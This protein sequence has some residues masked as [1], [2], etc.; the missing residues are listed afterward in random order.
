LEVERAAKLEPMYLALT[1]A[2]PDSDDQ[3]LQD[4]L[5]TSVKSAVDDQERG[6]LARAAEET[7]GLQ[8]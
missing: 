6:M 8:D 1:D 7:G 2:E 3:E 4:A 5:N